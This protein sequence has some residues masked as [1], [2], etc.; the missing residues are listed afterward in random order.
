MALGVAV[1]HYRHHRVAI[2]GL[3]NDGAACAY[4]ASARVMT[5]NTILGIVTAPLL[6]RVR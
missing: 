6:I 2:G 1:F 4:G 5:R 3:S